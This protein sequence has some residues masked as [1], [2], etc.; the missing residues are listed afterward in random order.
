MVSE[1][2]GFKR[3]RYHHTGIHFIPAGAAAPKQTGNSVGKDTEELDT[4]GRNVKWGNAL[5]D[6]L[7]VPQK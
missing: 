6:G 2:A 1:H 3:L 4:P 7:A 5:D